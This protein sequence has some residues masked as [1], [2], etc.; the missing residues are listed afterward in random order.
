[1]PAVVKENDAQLG[2]LQDARPIIKWAFDAKEGEVSEPFS[3]SNQFV[4]AVLTK[5]VKEGLPDVR[6]ARPLV[7]SF[8]RNKKKSEEIIKKVGKN[9][10]L[11]AAAAAYQKQ[12]LTAGADSTLTFNAAIINGVGNEPKVAGASFNKEYQTKVSPAIAGN[13]GVFVIK[14][15]SINAKPL[16]PSA[17]DLQQKNM[18][19]NQE[20]Q[21]AIGKSFEA[22]KKTADIKDKRSKFF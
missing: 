1:M 14:V 21:S 22:L 5:K 17:V 2:G 11:E 12:V 20:M 18:K 8:V 15:N 10:S 16:P 19:L 9:P 7:E 6:T 3:V 13:T 4:V